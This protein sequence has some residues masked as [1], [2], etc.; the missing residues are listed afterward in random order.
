MDLMAADGDS[1]GFIIN[2]QLDGR[3]NEIS[4]LPPWIIRLPMAGNTDTNGDRLQ[5]VVESASG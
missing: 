5:D 4:L 2:R 3:T 1:S